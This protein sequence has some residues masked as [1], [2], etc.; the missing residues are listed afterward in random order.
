M[1]LFELE[2]GESV[3][4]NLDT[5]YTATRVDEKTIEFKSKHDYSVGKLH[6]D[7]KTVEG[8]ASV[9]NM[10]LFTPDE[11]FVEYKSKEIRAGDV[12]IHV[13]LL[14]PR[15]E[16]IYEVTARIPPEVVSELVPNAKALEEVTLTK[17]IH[18][19]KLHELLKDVPDDPKVILSKFFPYYKQSIVKKIAK[20]HVKGYV[21][22]RTK[23]YV[24]NGRTVVIVDSKRKVVKAGRIVYPLQALDLF[25]TVARKIEK[26]VGE[27]VIA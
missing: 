10:V 23:T 18:G 20:G 26:I 5:E 3:E 1:K 17:K 4:V 13:E 16:A 19:D 12:T 24:S 15:Y 25:P 8:D 11:R 22:T 2:V 7:T 27:E 9:A 21:K 6:L 14:L